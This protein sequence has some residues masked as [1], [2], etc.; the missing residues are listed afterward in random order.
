MRGLRGRPRSVMLGGDALAAHAQVGLN[1]KKGFMMPCAGRLA[2]WVRGLR[3]RPRSVMLGGDALAAHAHVDP[4]MGRLI[5]FSHHVRLGL[6]GPV[7]RLTV[8]EFDQV[9]MSCLLRSSRMD[10]VPCGTGLGAAR[11]RPGSSQLPTLR[12]SYQHDI[13]IKVPCRLESTCDDR[14]AVLEHLPSVQDVELVA[15]AT[16]TLEGYALIHDIAVT[17]NHIV[18]FQVR[19]RVRLPREPQSTTP[20]M[21]DLGCSCLMHTP[22]LLRIAQGK[23]RYGGTHHAHAYTAPWIHEKQWALPVRRTRR[24]CACCRCCWG[25]QRRSTALSGREMDRARLCG[26]CRGRR[27]AR[28]QPTVPQ[29]VGHFCTVSTMCLHG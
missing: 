4:A 11:A 12:L 7:T 24:A 19:V 29:Q 9:G 20:Q 21:L 26:S 13:Y 8:Y 5:T 6:R 25:S 17:E 1:P 2:G 3:G 23:V 27:P 10:P 16:H 18:V 14:V 15:S 28:H 22:K